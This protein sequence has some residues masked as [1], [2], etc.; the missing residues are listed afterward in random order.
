MNAVAF[1]LPETAL[2]NL[3]DQFIAMDG[4]GDGVVSYQEFLT[5]MNGLEGTS[6]IG[7]GHQKIAAAFEAADVDGTGTWPRLLEWMAF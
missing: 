7:K 4:D 1:E 3:K 6:N 5:T 2:D